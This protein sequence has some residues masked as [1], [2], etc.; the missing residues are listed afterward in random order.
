MLRQK[1]PDGLYCTNPHPCDHRLLASTAAAWAR[2]M[3]AEQRESFVCAGCR[4]AEAARETLAV[5]RADAGRRNI[6]AAQKARR[7]LI[8]ALEPIRRDTVKTDRTDAAWQ[9]GF[10]PLAV[11][12]ANSGHRG[13]RP[14]TGT[15]R[16]ARRRRLADLRRRVADRD[17]QRAYRA[18]QRMS[19]AEV[20]EEVTA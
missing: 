20:K 12:G 9:I 8:P 13:G 17:R 7:V 16:W 1:Y 19:G 5:V 14:A 11:A 4:G 10:A 3:T 2:S 15:S 18:A 6:L